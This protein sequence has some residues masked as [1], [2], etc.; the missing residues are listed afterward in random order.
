M[1][2]LLVALCLVCPALAGARTISVDTTWRGKVELRETVRVEPG[3][4]LTVA[5]GSEVRFS[6]G[7]LEVAGRLVANGAHFSGRDWEGIVLKACGADTII[8]DSSVSGAA[9]GIFVGGG[10]PRLERL[11]VSG[12]QVGMELKQK[13]AATV[14]GCRIAGN[15]KVGLFIKDEA[16]PSVTNCRFEKNGKFGVYIHRAVPARFSG[17][18][19]LRNPTGLMVANYGSDPLV[20][21]NRFEENELGILVDRAARPLLRGNLLRGNSTGLRLYRRSD[22]LVEGNRLERNGTAISVAFSSYPQLRGND[23]RDNGRALFLEFQSSA[24]EEEKGESTRESESAGRGAFGSGAGRSEVTEAERRPRERNGLVDA[25]DNWWGER[26]SAEL[27]RLGADGNPGF[28]QDGRDTP[29]FVEGG[30]TYPLDRV[31]FAPWRRTP[32]TAHWT[33]E[34]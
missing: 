18:V 25:R 20:E 7:R 4:T 23:F 2:L 16:L 15:A 1:R 11:E 21:G 17:N 14:T 6:G 22:A 26:E 3:A 19:L 30:K 12:N 32:A 9:T 10:Q 33:S 8:A 13:T 24:W 29:T 34:P 5:P 31:V 28:I 27:E